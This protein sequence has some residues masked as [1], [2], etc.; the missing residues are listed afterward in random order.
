M[1]LQRRG[2]RNQPIL[3]KRTFPRDLPGQERQSQNQLHQNDHLKPLGL[4]QPHAHLGFSH[5]I[6]KFENHI[7]EL[8]DH[9]R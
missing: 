9:P 7:Q 1:F 5:R 6:D 3:D 8:L 2:F 4:A